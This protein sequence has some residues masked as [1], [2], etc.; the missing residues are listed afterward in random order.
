MRIE[1]V[2]SIIPLC[3]NRAALASNCLAEDIPEWIRAI[4]FAFPLLNC[5]EISLCPDNTNIM[6]GND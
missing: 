5:V 6:V 4:E 1:T 2:S 3:Y